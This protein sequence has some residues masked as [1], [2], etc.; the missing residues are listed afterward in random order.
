[1]ETNQL[2]SGIRHRLIRSG[3]PTLTEFNQI[4]TIESLRKHLQVA[5]ELEHS[6][7][8][9]YLFALYSI[10][11]N[12]NDASARAIKGVVMEEMLHMIL[13]CNLL[14]AVG[15]EPAIS[16]RDFVPVYPTYLPH[17]NEAF[18]VSLQKFSRPAIDTFLKIEKPGGKGAPPQADRYASIGQFYEA[19]V[20]GLKRLA[21]K[22]NIFTGDR[23]RQIRPEQFYGGGGGLIEIY[24]LETA[25]EAISEIVGQGEGIDDTIEDNNH[26][27]FGEEVEY[28]HYFRFNEIYKE[29]YYKPTDTPKSGPTG[30]KFPV[31]WNQVHN[32]KENI[33]MNDFKEGTEER[34]MM[35]QFNKRYCDMLRLIHKT[36]NGKREKLEEAVMI[37]YQLKYL[38][39][40]LMNVPMGNGLYAAPSFEYVE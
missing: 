10:R 4:T 14:N 38:A 33:K 13:A 25:E 37:M 3:E 1:M 28:A 24:D 7:I 30:G 35:H 19:I 36:V 21:A 18:K 8:P 17:S 11:E 20:D 39:Q 31:D 27:L 16:H 23:S 32:L 2:I 26:K 15:G 6:T 5:I 12:T 22:G 34:A 40:G 29:Q 9:P